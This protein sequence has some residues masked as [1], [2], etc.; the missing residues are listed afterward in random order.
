MK[1][2]LLLAALLPGFVCAQF[3]LS[4]EE[5]ASGYTRACEIV[6]AGDERLFILEQPGRIRILY[7][8]GEQVSEPF[9]DITD[10]VASVGEQGLL[11]LAFPENYCFEG[12]FYV[13][14]TLNIGGDL[15]T[16]ISSFQVDPENENQALEDSEEVL[17]EFEQDFGN[18]NGGQL[19]FGP[20]GMLYIFTGD[21]G[22]S[23]DPFNRAQNIMSHL[24]KILRIDVSTTPYSIP[25]DNPFAFDDFGLDEIWAYGLR[26]PWKNAFDEETG[27]LYIADVGQSNREE[28]NVQMAG[29]EGGANYGWK[30]YE[31][32]Q[33]FDLDD[34]EG[35]TGVVDPVFDYAYGN[36]GNGFRCSV[37]GGRVYR[38]ES[39]QNLI[40]KYIFTDYC[41]GEYWV[42]WQENDEWEVFT[43]PGLGGSITA[44]GA[45]V[46]GELYAV[47]NSQFT[48]SA[49][50]L[51]EGSG[52]FREHILFDGMDLLESALEGESYQWFLDGEP[53]EGATSQTLQITQNGIY[54]LIIT[55]LNGC[56]IETNEF[57]VNSL[58]LSD[59][60]MVENFSIFPNP[61][62][63]L[64]NVELS[65]QS[66]IKNVVLEIYSVDGRLIEEENINT[67]GRIELD[68]GNL[69]KG[70][71]LL[72]L[73]HDGGSF[74]GSR[75]L[76]ID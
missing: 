49:N 1:K 8:D 73:T 6:N 31:G 67:H 14:Y 32:S 26:N 4:L 74:L 45:D 22:S 3:D 57:E 11:G 18:H 13:N 58:S 66:A 50:R 35:V 27:D 24:G 55:S 40:G 70:V 5:I 76:I 54:S 9:L 41:S 71:Y 30:C 68:L 10:Q 62:E 75:K 39:F 52:S 65:F 20:D 7:P 28:V 34:C 56:E 48:N 38:G 44:F 29:A 47:R 63:G 59:N 61:S 21:G 25:P 2:A 51:I 64:V 15:H 16:R 46:W 42:M 37:T 19:E 72:R 17:M 69:R 53:I 33:V 23:G 36:Q 43:A 12:K 60:E